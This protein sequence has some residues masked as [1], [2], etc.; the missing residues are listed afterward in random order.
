MLPYIDVNLFNLLSLYLLEF[1]HHCD[2]IVRNPCLNDFKQFVSLCLQLKIEVNLNSCIKKKAV[3]AEQEAHD[4][5]GL[6]V[7]TGESMVMYNT[8][9]YIEC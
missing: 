7:D 6:D 3:M 1:V 8:H 2:I 5:S 9:T 4:L